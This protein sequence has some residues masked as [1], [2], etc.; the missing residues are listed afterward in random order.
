MQEQPL[1]SAFSKLY[2]AIGL[3]DH[4]LDVQLALLTEEEQWAQHAVQSVIWDAAGP[5][6]LVAKL[7]Y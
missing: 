3:Y 6:S 5:S 2:E 4:W 1:S 7:T